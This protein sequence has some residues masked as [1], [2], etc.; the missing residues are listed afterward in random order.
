MARSSGS[1]FID[2]VPDAVAETQATA[3]EAGFRAPRRPRREIRAVQV[4]PCGRMIE[5][6][7]HLFRIVRP[8]GR[9]M[10]Y[11]LGPNAARQQ[12]DEVGLDEAPLLLAL[13]RPRIREVDAHTGKARRCDAL[14]E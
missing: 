2:Q 13:L 6:L 10:Q 14:L 8:I 12:R 9:Q 4:A 11:A 1:A 7:A 3:F 5:Y